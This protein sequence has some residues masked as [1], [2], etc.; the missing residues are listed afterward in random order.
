MPN[1]LRKHSHHLDRR[2][3]FRI[4]LY[5]IITVI[6]L[7]VIIFN[8]YTHALR[9]TLGLIGLAAGIGIG[10]IT[11]RMFKMS[12]D[13]DAKKIVGRLDIYGIIILVIY[14]GFEIFR[15]KIV[16]YFTHNFQVAPVGFAVL[17]GIMFGRVLGTYTW[18]IKILKEQE[19]L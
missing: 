4:I 14:V 19:I 10:I 3:R 1:S 2:L 12:W 6:L 9:P 18:V 15:G 13:K 7:G 16:G 5:M 17:A 11:T 8:I